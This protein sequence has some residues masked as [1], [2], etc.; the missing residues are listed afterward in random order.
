MDRARAGHCG[1]RG[2]LL[3]LRGVHRGRSAKLLAEQLRAQ[4]VW[5]LAGYTGKP[6][7]LCS[8]SLTAKKHSARRNGRS[9][10]TRDHLRV[11]EGLCPKAE[12]GLKHLLT[13][14][15]DESWTRD[16]SYERASA[17]GCLEGRETSR[18]GVPPAALR[19]RRHR[20]RAECSGGASHR[21]R[22]GSRSSVAVRW[23]AGTW[24]YSATRRGGRGVCGHLTF[25]AERFAAYVL[26]G[27]TGRT[28]SAG[29]EQV[30]A[31]SVCSCRRR[32]AT[33]PWTCCGGSARAV[34]E[35]VGDVTV[36]RTR[37]GRRR[38]QRGT[39][40]SPASNSGSSTRCRKRR[41]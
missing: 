19:P 24:R 17:G 22:C 40:P 23:A 6:I 34:R 32:T 20:R 41:S 35:A 16:A 8:E 7:Y 30:D 25:H 10:T 28:E 37:H 27:R 4:K 15:L 38:H 9:I 2:V 13:L 36:R 31:V 14:P 18:R 29:A 11:R 33:S 1:G 26:D 39:A 12:A 3:G 21:S 5:A